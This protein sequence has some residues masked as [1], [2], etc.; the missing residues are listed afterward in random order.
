[1]HVLLWCVCFAILSSFVQVECGRTH[2]HHHHHHHLGKDER[3]NVYLNEFAVKIDG[4]D[5]DAQA[6]ASKYGLI[7]LGKVKSLLIVCWYCG[8]YDDI[9]NL[10]AALL[11][12][13]CLFLKFTPAI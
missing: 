12:A 9:G 4:S 10:L 6:I 7:N 13:Y 3:P 5:V 1:M 2:P 11:E 8:C